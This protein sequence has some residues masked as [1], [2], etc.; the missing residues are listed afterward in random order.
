[1][2]SLTF[3]NSYKAQLK[4]NYQ[5]SSEI[6]FLEIEKQAIKNVDYKISGRLF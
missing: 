5:L 2:I 1:M 6:L 4:S 3:F